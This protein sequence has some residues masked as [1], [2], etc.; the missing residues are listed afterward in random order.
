MK[1]YLRRVSGIMQ[2]FKSEKHGH[3][4]KGWPNNLDGVGISFLMDFSASRN[5]YDRSS[6]IALP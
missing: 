5:F 1:K 6:Q 4:M 3:F 2:V